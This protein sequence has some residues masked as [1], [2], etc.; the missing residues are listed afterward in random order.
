[1]C[2]VQMGDIVVLS[3]LIVFLLSFVVSWSSLFTLS[4]SFHFFLNIT[5]LLPCKGQHAVFVKQ[6]IIKKY[7]EEKK[8]MRLCKSECLV[9]K[10]PKESKKEGN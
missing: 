1:M 2:N 6:D 10:D 4:N 7:L 8:E 5:F 9:W 3:G